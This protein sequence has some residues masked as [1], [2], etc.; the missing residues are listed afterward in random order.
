MIAIAGTEGGS[1]LLICGWAGGSEGGGEYGCAYEIHDFV[2]MKGGSWVCW[3]INVHCK[4]SK[5]AWALDIYLQPK[6]ASF[7]YE[8]QGKRYL[9][10]VALHVS[11]G[12]CVLG[13]I[14][15]R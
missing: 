8:V 2:E 3:W 7:F 15:F 12:H 1:Q 9:T 11:K 4:Y 13:L 6:F 10:G 5:I 14:A